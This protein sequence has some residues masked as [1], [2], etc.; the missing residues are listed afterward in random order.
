[1]P[2]EAAA[3]DAAALIP[4]LAARL[5]LAADDA[6]VVGIGDPVALDGCAGSYGQATVAAEVAA[7]VPERGPVA[8]WGGLGIY[9]VVWRLAKAG[10]EPDWV[11]PS[12]GALLDAPAK[13][14]LARTLETF[15]DLAGDVQATAAA[16]HLHRT[17]LYHRLQRMET[18]TGVP[19][20]AGHERTSLHLALK[21]ARYR[22]MLADQPVA[23]GVDGWARAC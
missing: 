17:T 18:V 8:A 13:L 2:A 14:D 19:L 12:F 7:A 15:L 6:L 22:G 11:H 23:P 16:L 10:A 20:R 5:G 3:I 9:R 4:Q 21:L 1:M